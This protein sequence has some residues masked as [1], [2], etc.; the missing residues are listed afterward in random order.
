VRLMYDW[1]ILSKRNISDFIRGK[2]GF[3]TK[4]II[5]WNQCFFIKKKIRKN[6]STNLSI[7]NKNGYNYSNFKKYYYKHF[8]IKKKMKTG[9]LTGKKKSINISTDWIIIFIIT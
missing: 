6:C 1:L 3:E 4:L 5:I 2:T 7:E 9:T 8:N